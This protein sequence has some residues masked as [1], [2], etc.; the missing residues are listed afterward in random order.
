MKAYSINTKIEIEAE[1]ELYPIVGNKYRKYFLD[2][3]FYLID[4]MK[5]NVNLY[6]ICC[7][8]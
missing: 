4:P 6:Y 7:I 5:V 1:I 3:I 2:N 8:V